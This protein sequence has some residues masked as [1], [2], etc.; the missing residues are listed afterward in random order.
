MNQSSRAAARQKIE[1]EKNRASVTAAEHARTII[2]SAE[3]PIEP[4]KMSGPAVAPTHH[5]NLKEP[6]MAHQDLKAAGTTARQP[7]LNIEKTQPTAAEQAQGPRNLPPGH[8][9]SPGHPS[10][11]Q[12]KQ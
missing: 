8:P 12:P 11:Q 5:Q 9:D 6:T 10:K 2:D 1:L 4:L 7:T 3:L